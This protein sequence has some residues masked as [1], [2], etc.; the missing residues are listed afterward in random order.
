MNREGRERERESK[1][2]V[3][4]IANFHASQNRSVEE[5]EEGR[6]LNAREAVELK[7]RVVG[8]RQ[9]AVPGK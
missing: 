2:S 3:H 8:R 9:A 5:E 7:L 1:K 4:K 6:A